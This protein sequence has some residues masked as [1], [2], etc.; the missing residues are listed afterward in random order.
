MTP[1]GSGIVGASEEVAG[2][3]W[4]T[5]RRRLRHTAAVHPESLAMGW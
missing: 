1:T 3:P 5:V 4:L 2:G